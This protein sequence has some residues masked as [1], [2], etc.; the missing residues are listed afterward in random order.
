MQ[1]WLV[2]DDP[3]N[4]NFA[5]SEPVFGAVAVLISAFTKFD[6]YSIC[7][8][9]ITMEYEIT[10]NVRQ[11]NWGVWMHYTIADSGG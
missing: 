5:L 8:A 10:N 7:I 2:G 9:I 6:K 1:K 11:L 3:L 4:V